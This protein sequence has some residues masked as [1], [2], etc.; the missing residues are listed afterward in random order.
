MKYWKISAI[1][2]IIVMAIFSYILHTEPK[3]QYPD[4]EQRQE[5]WKQYGG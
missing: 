5:D 2:A 4:Y 1:L 3:G